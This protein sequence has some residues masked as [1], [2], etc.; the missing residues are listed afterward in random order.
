MLNIVRFMAINSSKISPYVRTAIGINTGT[1]NYTDASGN[2][3]NLGGTRATDLAYQG[4]IG[5]K[6]ALSKNAGI[7]AEAGYGH[8]FFME[9]HFL[10]SN[11]SIIKHSNL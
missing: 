8:I 4:A 11:L 5:V 1:Q 3:I 10:N 9:E 7:F 6:L 2:K